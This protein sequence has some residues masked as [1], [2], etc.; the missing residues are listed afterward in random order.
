MQQL[1][2]NTLVQYGRE[3]SEPARLVGYSG[4]GT[5]AVLT[6]GKLEFRVPAGDV[7]R[8]RVVKRTWILGRT[9]ARVVIS[10]ELLGET[11]ARGTIYRT[12][13]GWRMIDVD[14]TELGV[15]DGD[16][17]DAER[18]LLDATAVF[19]EVTPEDLVF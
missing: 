3:A 1:A 4:D 2:P 12:A 9:S 8:H 10:T 16:Y 19:D 18:R 17:I 14:H 6:Y 11:W 5:E 13:E 15:H 7:R